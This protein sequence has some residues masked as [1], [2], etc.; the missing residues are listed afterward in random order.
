MPPQAGDGSSF[1]IDL[2]PGKT[3]VDKF[4]FILEKNDRI[5]GLLDIVRDYP[6]NNIWWIG[7]FLIHPQ[8]RGKG[9]GKQVVQMLCRSLQ[10]Y[11]AYEIRLGVLEENTSGYRFWQNSGFLQI[12]TK[13]GR[14]FG[15]KTHT[16][17]VMG[18]I[19]SF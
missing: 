19:L 8:F 12:E 5:I 11:G 7:L 18:R 2:P 6:A 13:P 1:L 10:K 17:F 16:V 9:L 3:Q 14:Q 4:A 15:N